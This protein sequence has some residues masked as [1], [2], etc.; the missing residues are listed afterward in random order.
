MRYWDTYYYSQV[1]HNLLVRPEDYLRLL[2][3]FFGDLRYRSFIAPYP[4]W[5]TL[6]R[7]VEQAFYGILEESVDDI[8]VD[9]IV[10][11]PDYEPWVS[12]ALDEHGINHPHIRDWLPTGGYR[13]DEVDEDVVYQ[14]HDHL[15]EL[16]SLGSLAT[17]LAEE[18]F[19]LTF[20][21]RNLLRRLHEEIAERVREVDPVHE[22]AQDASHFERKGVLRRVRPPQWAQRAVFFRDRGL[23]TLCHRDLS[24]LLSSQSTE[25]YDHIIPLAK[26]GTNEVT[27]LQ[28]LC[29]SCNV[30]K[31]AVRGRAG[32]EYERWYPTS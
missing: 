11:R 21:N 27:N 7:F 15:T 14:Y 19:F 28:L 24:G 12:E 30:E 23:C 1:V 31:G 2:E 6:H 16:G 17:Q 18:V 26:G 25:A 10:H 3:D 29:Q 4:R 20:L 32:D 8:M 13:L 22:A 9:A 5:T